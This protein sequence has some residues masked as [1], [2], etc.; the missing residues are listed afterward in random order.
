MSLTPFGS[1][2]LRVLI[3]GN[4]K[5]MKKGKN[6]ND[7]FVYSSTNFIPRRFVS[8]DSFNLFPN[9]IAIKFTAI[10]FHEEI[11]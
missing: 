2:W 11:L 4:V 7:C 1:K 8:L 3:Y 6:E 10:K 5:R 9:V